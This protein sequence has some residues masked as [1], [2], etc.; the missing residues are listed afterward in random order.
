[1]IAKPFPTCGTCFFAIPD[2]AGNL[3]CHGA[4]PTSFRV[5]EDRYASAYPPVGADLKG[6]AVHKPARNRRRRT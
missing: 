5:A 2:E 4:P 1:M 6:C 3:W